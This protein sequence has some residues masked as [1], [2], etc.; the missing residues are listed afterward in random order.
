MTTTEEATEATTAEP[1][2]E[3]TA[4]VPPEERPIEELADAFDRAWAAQVDIDRLSQRVVEDVKKSLDDIHRA[5]IVTIVRALRDDPRGKE[6]L[7]G[8]VDEPIVRWVLTMHEVIRPNP[9][10]IAQDALDTIRPQL[11]SHGGDVELDSIEDGVAYVRLQGACNG[12][13]MSAVTMRN[14]VEEALVAAVPGVSKVEVL[15]NEPGPTLIGLSEIGGLSGSGGTVSAETGWVKAM[16]IDK[17]VLGAVTPVE[18]ANAVVVNIAG[19]LTAYVNECAHMGLP[20]DDAEIDEKTGMMT[21]SWHGYCFDALSG[22]C[23]SLPGAQLEQL[24]L[25][26]DEGHVWIRTG[27]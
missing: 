13:S 24:P 20:L 22:E 21:C 16:E 11:Q 17:F 9:M 23:T 6:L 3:R 12:C 1:T 4:P 7:F 2:A 8:L 18:E 27:A 25:R 10:I 19:Q 14:G 5:A 26:V 15:P